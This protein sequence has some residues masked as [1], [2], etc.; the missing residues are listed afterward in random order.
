MIHDMNHYGNES[1]SSGGVMPNPN[2]TP[3][4]VS[5]LRHAGPHLGALAIVYTVLF[6]AGLYPVTIFASKTHFP[7]P[8]EPGD[9]IVSYFQTHALPVLM[10]AFLQFGATIALGIFT[11]SVVSRLHFLG[12]RAAGPYIALFGG[13]ATV[14][15]GM[16]ASS[17]L[18]VM[19]PPGIAQAATLPRAMYYLSYP[20]R[21][22]PLS[23]ARGPLLTLLP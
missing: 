14:F 7:G 4:L 15:G 6:N 13:F 21:R 19:I 12:V 23:R 9:V 16:A 1:L 8:W 17:I 20:F 10:C 11:A 3:Q 2:E 22:S 18:W 5:P